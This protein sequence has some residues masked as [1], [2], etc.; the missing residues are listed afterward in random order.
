M[1]KHDSFSHGLSQDQIEIIRHILAPYADKINK[2]G[3][4]G[5]RATGNAKSTSDID[6][7]LYGDIDESIVNR[8]WTLFGESNLALE[9]D[10]NAYDLIAY[11][12]LKA[13]IDSTMQPLFER[14][15]LGGS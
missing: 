14:E 10:I 13:H 3:L 9:V 6:L 8:L 15:D 4:F 5:S 12:P 11:P 7:V 1:Q 2:V